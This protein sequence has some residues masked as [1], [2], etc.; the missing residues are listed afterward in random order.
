[1]AVEQVEDFVAQRLPPEV[2]ACRY[3]LELA[4]LSL[5]AKEQGVPVRRLL[6]PACRDTVRVNALLVER[7]P[8]ALAREARARVS[9]GFTTLKLKLGLGSPTPSPWPEGDD[10]AGLEADLAR[11]RAVRSAVGAEF[12]LRLD[13]NGAWTPAQAKRAVASLVEVAPQLIEQPVAGD[14]LEGLREVAKDSPIPIF[15]DEAL[16]TVE[17]VRSVLFDDRG[18]AVP[19]L[20]LKPTALGGLMPALR[21]ALS[22]ARLGV[23][24][25][26][27]H[28]MDGEVARAGAWELAAAIP[29]RTLAS[30]VD[31]RPE[32]TA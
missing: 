26:V 9:Q 22:A 10:G 23:D 21:I 2:P 27:T 4:L 13:A 17:G 30:G 12:P 31:S 1:L 15:A 16:G 6:N 29:Q 32:G 18:P 28:A 7:E 11:A 5:L 14:D 25:F 24:A 19:G 20:V 8:A 3:G